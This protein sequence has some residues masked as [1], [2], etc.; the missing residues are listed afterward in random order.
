MTSDSEYKE[1]IKY[2]VDPKLLKDGWVFKL[3]TLN[4]CVELRKALYIWQLIAISFIFKCENISVITPMG[5][6]IL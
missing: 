2:S 6:K 1:S 3:H 5:R 4:V